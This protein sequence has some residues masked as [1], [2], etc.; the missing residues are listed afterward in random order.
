MRSLTLSIVGVLV[1]IKMEKEHRCI[2]CN[3]ILRSPRAIANRMG[4][5]CYRRV[6]GI[7][8]GERAEL[9]S[10]IRIRYNPKQKHL[11]KGEKE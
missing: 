8:K 9:Q 4:E 5:K 6:I 10:R 3:R 2:V 1:G 7:A 11:F